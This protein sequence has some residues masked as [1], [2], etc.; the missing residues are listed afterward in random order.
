MKERITMKSARAKAKAWLE[1]SA[2]EE[3]DVMLYRAKLTPRQKS[4]VTL[5]YCEGLFNYQIAGRLNVSPETIRN[6]I[7]AA[8]DKVAPLS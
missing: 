7:A 3:F 1:C 8:H 6:E 4:I 5:R 2:R